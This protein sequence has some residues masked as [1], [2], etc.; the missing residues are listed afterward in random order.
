MRSVERMLRRADLPFKSTA[1]FHPTPRVHFALSLPL[2]VEGL[3]EVVEME[4]TRELDAE[5]ALAGLNAQAPAGLAFTRVS[6]VPLRTTAMPRRAI[7]RMALPPDR[8]DEVAARSAELMD[9]AKVWVDR[10]RPAP[11]RLNIRPYFRSL[12]VQPH[13]PTPLSQGERGALRDTPPPA[14]E[15]PGE[16]S[17]LVL[18][19]WVTQTGTARADELLKLLHL[20]DL[21]ESGAVMERLTVELHDEAPNLDAADVPPIGPAE[22]LPLDPAAAA[23][24]DRRDEVEVTAAA[25]WGASPAGPVVE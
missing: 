9:E 8:L 5:D 2:G 21:P 7:Y 6:V 19:F 12:T 11:K 17:F 18:D 15:G 22:T 3:D 14:G 24:L 1:G 16:R 10:L 20:A 25:G 4:F 13:P 23:A